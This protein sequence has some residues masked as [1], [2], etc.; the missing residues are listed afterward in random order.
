MMLGCGRCG[1][2][3]EATVMYTTCISSE[4]YEVGDL[5]SG[6]TNKTIKHMICSHCQLVVQSV[7]VE[8]VP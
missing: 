5:L 8:I 3:D 4:D 2:T 1:H 7:M 6:E